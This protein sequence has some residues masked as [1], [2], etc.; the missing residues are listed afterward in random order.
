[1]TGA[2]R[3]IGAA[4]ARSLSAA[5]A[6]V[7]LVARSESDLRMVASGVQGECVVLVADLEGFGAPREL[8]AQVLGEHGSVDILVN[9]AGISFNR[10]SHKL[11]ADD[12]DRVLAINVRTPLVLS[13]ALA[14]AML[15]EGRGAIVN[16]SSLSGLRGSSFQAAYSASKGALDALTRSL[17]CEWGPGG[18]RV[19]S[20]APGVIVTD[21]WESGRA[22]P[23]VV[24]AFEQ[25]IALRRWGQPDDVADV[26][27]WLASD[28]SR[29]VTGQTISVDGGMSTMAYQFQWDL[30]R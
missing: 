18:I 19:N 15:K 11:Q 5:G 23:G 6:K 30:Q 28:A 2:S 25:Q 1:M 9:N 12:I 16:V 29:Y 20:V 26:V 4:C 22:Q 24:E 10:R 13:A 17:A 14:P 27:A 8:A 21:M 3:G 7:I